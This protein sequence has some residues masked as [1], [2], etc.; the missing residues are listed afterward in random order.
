MKHLWHYAMRE[1]IKTD[2]GS[3]LF[4]FCAITFSFKDALLKQNT[5]IVC[6]TA[7]TATGIVDNRADHRLIYS[8]L[9]L[10]CLSLAE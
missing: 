9:Q 5:D 2:L 1:M 7:T 4:Y 3:V 10:R 8:V 6:D